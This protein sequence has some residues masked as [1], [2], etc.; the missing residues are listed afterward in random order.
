MHLASRSPH[1]VTLIENTYDK[2]IALGKSQQ[3]LTDYAFYS[4]SLGQKLAQ[5][6]IEFNF[7]TAIHGSR[8]ALTITTLCVDYYA[9]FI[10]AF[11]MPLFSQVGKDS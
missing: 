2:T 7:S 9:V 10:H 8:L 1:E 6:G 5:H 3:L 4:D 11:A